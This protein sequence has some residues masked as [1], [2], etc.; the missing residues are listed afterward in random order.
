MDKITIDKMISDR[1]E[2]LKG[3]YHKD[4]A[5]NYLKEISRKNKVSSI[6]EII[7]ADMYG[8]YKGMYYIRAKDFLS[9]EEVCDRV[10]NYRKF[11]DGLSDRSVIVLYQLCLKLIETDSIGKAILFIKEKNA[12]VANSIYSN[13]GC[14]DTMSKR[15]LKYLKRESDDMLLTCFTWF[16]SDLRDD[17]DLLDLLE[18]LSQKEK[19][20]SMNDSL[21]SLHEFITD[22][23]GKNISNN[24]IKSKITDFLDLRDLYEK[25][26]VVSK[27]V[28]EEENKEKK[29]NKVTTSEISALENASSL[30]NSVADNDEITCARRIAKDIYDYDIKY[31]VLQFIDEHN[32]KYYEKLDKEIE[33]LSSTTED[34]YKKLLNDYNIQCDGVDVN[35]LKSKSLEEIEEMIKIISAY[36]LD[37]NSNLFILFNASKERVVKLNDLVNKCVLPLSFLST[38][39]DLYLEDSEKYTVLRDN[40]NTLCKY[41]INPK[42]FYDS[43]SL[44]LTSSDLLSKNL[45]ILNKYDLLNL[46]TTDNFE[47]LINNR[48]NEKIDLLLELGY[49]EFL[50]N[51]LCLLNQENYNRLYVIKELGIEINN[52]D[53]LVDLLSNDKR[54]F[55]PNNKLDLYIPNGERDKDKEDN[56]ISLEDLEEYRVSKRVY[57]FGDELVSYNKVIDNISNGYE[58]YDAIFSNMN[59][60]NDEIENIYN[61]IN[62]KKMIKKDNN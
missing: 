13:F 32:R 42:L 37:N 6:K 48:L 24:T 34:S 58:I 4:P 11:I 12:D 53:E 19:V 30:L 40:L 21:D 59:L 31:S 1:I 51:N 3:S 49:E 60:S 45:E 35:L 52:C 17:E 8:L 39:I 7:D 20:S 29:Y 43:I 10:D 22:F 18:L 38:N 54:F 46:K 50:V 36:N 57:S 44:L 27:Y 16:L 23:T 5:F 55:I 25:I 47:F 9:F 41:D 26:S 62:Q 33:R 56:N 28:K 14:L 15:L 2:Y 61:S